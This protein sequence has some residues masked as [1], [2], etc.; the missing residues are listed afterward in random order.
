MFAI[1]MSSLGVA[2][3][4]KMLFVLLLKPHI[5]TVIAVYLSVVPKCAQD[6]YNTHF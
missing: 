6:D 4:L 3:F 1:C 2:N 5:L